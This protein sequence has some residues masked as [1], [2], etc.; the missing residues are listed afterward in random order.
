[1]ILLLDVCGARNQVGLLSRRPAINHKSIPIST[2]LPFPLLT[3]FP[4][5]I[6][7]SL[8]RGKSLVVEFCFFLFVFVSHNF[9]PAT[10]LD[11][12]TSI[13]PLLT[14][15][16]PL[17]TLVGLFHLE[18]FTIINILYSFEF[19]FSSLNHGIVSDQFSYATQQCRRENLF[20]WK[21]NLFIGFEK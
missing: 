4:A 6:E 15:L 8:L 12:E 16:H 19:F 18:L 7:P 5:Y 13:L 3:I 1:M 17:F 21:W 14:F 9:Q 10:F 20:P 11:L 2:L